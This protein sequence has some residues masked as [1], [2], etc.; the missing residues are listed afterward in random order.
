MNYW[1]VVSTPLKNISQNGNPPQIGVKIKNTWDHHLDLYKQKVQVVQK[2]GVTARIMIIHDD[3]SLLGVYPINTHYIRCIWVWLLIV[4]SQ[5]YHHFLIPKEGPT[6]GTGTGSGSSSWRQKVV[7]T[8]GFWL[9]YNP[10]RLTCWTP[11]LV[12]FFNVSPFPRGWFQVPCSF[13]G[14][15]V[16]FEKNVV[17]RTSRFSWWRTEHSRIS[18]LNTP[19]IIANDD[20]LR[21]R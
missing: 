7:E 13:S 15:D 12:L 14:V 1:L 11:K 2:T 20:W 17:A 16:D 8:M 3:S 21:L 19:H 9:E 5:K 18:R 4:P 10:R 6:P